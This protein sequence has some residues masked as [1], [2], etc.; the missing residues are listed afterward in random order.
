MASILKPFG[1]LLSPKRTVPT[2]QLK[3]DWTHPLTQG[4][5]ACYVPGVSGGINLTGQGADLSPIVPNT[6]QDSTIEGPGWLTVTAGDGLKAVAPA[7]FLGTWSGLSFYWRGYFGTASGLGGMVIGIEH[8]DPESNPYIYAAITFGSNGSPNVF[9]DSNAGGLVSLNTATNNPN[10][11]MSVGATLPVSTASNVICYQNGAQILTPAALFGIPTT[12]ATTTICLQSSTAANSRSVPATGNIACIWK[13]PLSADEMAWLDREPYCFLLP[14]EAEMPALFVSAAG[15]S[16]PSDCSFLFQPTQLPRPVPIV[17]IQERKGYA[18]QDK[19]TPSPLTFWFQ[20]PFLGPVP[21]TLDTNQPRNVLPETRTR[22]DFWL[23]PTLDLQRHV[24]TIYT[25]QSFVCNPTIGPPVP[26]DAFWV[27]PPDLLNH[28]HSLDT[29]QPVDNF[30]SGL[31]QN[32]TPSSLGFWKQPSNLLWHAPTLDTNQPLNNTFA[33]WTDDL[34]TP[35]SFGFWNQPVNLVLP[36]LGLKTGEPQLFNIIGEAPKAIGWYTQPL[37]LNTLFVQIDTNQG[38]VLVVPGALVTPSQLAFWTQPPDLLSHPQT[39]STSQPR[40]NEFSGLSGGTPSPLGFWTQPPDLERHSVTLDTNQAF[41]YNPPAAPPSISWNVQAP[42]L[43][44]HPATVDTNQSF[45]TYRIGDEPAQTLGWH[46]QPHGLTRRLPVI[47][48]NFGRCLVVP[49]TNTPPSQLAFW[50]PPQD[51]LR[52]PAT[53]DTN[54]SRVNY[55]AQA[56]VTGL[57][58]WSQPPDLERHPAQLD[59]NQP[60]LVGQF[61]ATPSALAFWHQ[62]EDLLRHPP[63]LDTNQSRLVGQGGVTQSAL[64]FW[65]QPVDLLFHPVTI[66]TNQSRLVQQIGSTPASLGWWSQPPDLLSH[67]RTKRLSAWGFTSSF[68]PP[69]VPQQPWSRGYLI[70]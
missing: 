10:T 68:S 15:P 31:A 54:Q 24:P 4:L 66:D 50:T 6:W 38:R 29:N 39:L 47:E 35:S 14:A 25:A 13:R 67:P 12:A 8:S 23:V 61:R 44:A 2:G 30:F 32:P 9:W 42:S 41:V 7:N 19:A 17:N 43:T 45:D 69:I 60:V 59:T 11:F 63:Q 20:P 36:K 64:G 56:P 70:Q 49:Q 27:Q 51:L 1:N 26:V 53:L 62:P 37:S 46:F 22:T 5:L 58:F 55:Q 33:G 40:D 21:K 52:H 34:L 57:A 16:T 48:T 18:P 3:I 28:P 65:K